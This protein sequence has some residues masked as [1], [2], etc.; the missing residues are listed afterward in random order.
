MTVER[1]IVL[2]DKNEARRGPLRF[3]QFLG[4]LIDD[5]LWALVEYFLLIEVRDRHWS[6]GRSEEVAGGTFVRK[7]GFT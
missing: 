1:W 7:D 4:R 5:W 3:G 2:L 6:P